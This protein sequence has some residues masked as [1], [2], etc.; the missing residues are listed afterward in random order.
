MPRV[1]EAHPQGA[2]LQG[3]PAAPPHRTHPAQPRVVGAQQR[4]SRLRQRRAVCPAHHLRLP[5]EAWAQYCRR[6]RVVIMCYL[7]NI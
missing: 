7:N 1:R 3:P 6:V 4:R 5:R 2:E